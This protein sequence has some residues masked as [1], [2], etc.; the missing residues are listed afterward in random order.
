LVERLQGVRFERKTDGQPALGFI[1]EDVE[2]VLPEVVERDEASGRVLGVSYSAIVPVLVEAIKE[3]QHQMAMYR[4]ELL[5]QQVKLSALREQMS[6]LQVLKVR[7]KALEEMVITG[8]SD[9]VLAHNQ[10]EVISQ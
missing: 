7:L 4:E 8:K 6:E 5:E 9:R 10:G 1:A 2:P 3:Q